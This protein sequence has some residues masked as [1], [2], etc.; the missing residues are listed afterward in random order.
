M[1]AWRGEGVGGE[2]GGTFFSKL[3]ELPAPA[4]IVEQLLI[5]WVLVSF[6]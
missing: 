6:E 5:L 1:A 4:P 2:G 3:L